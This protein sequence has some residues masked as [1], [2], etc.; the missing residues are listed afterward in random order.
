MRIVK[1]VVRWLLIFLCLGALFSCGL[2]SVSGIMALLIAVLA[3]P[4]GPIR[5]LWKKILPPESPRFA[6]GAILAAAFLV[7]VAAAPGAAKENEATALPEATPVPSPVVTTTPEPTPSP[8]PVSTPTATPAPTPVAT[9]EPTP[10]PTLAPTPV[11]VEEIPT[12]APEQPAAAETG[13]GTTTT[14]PEE[15]PTEDTSA[16]TAPQSGTVYI[17]GSGNG[18]RYHSNPNCSSMNDP[19]PLTQAEAEARGYTPCKKCYK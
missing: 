2:F 5:A 12:A 19:V 6:K 10:T 18:K 16:Y 11:P 1:N 3:L 15:V 9:P 14:V 17:A 4:F 8:T 7:V 13:N